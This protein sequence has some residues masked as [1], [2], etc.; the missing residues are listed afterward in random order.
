MQ[1]TKLQRDK[2][3]SLSLKLFG[4]ESRWRKVWEETKIFDKNVVIPNTSKEY[5][6]AKAEALAGG[7]DFRAPQYP[8]YRKPTF[9]ETI[10][11]LQ[12]FSDTRD[13]Q[14]L[15]NDELV[16][17]AAS[18]FTANKLPVALSLIVEEDKKEEFTNL[19]GLVP[20][21]RH[22]WIDKMVNA[23]LPPGTGVAIDGVAFVK[24]LIYV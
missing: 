16:Q 21:D 20:S 6:I 13:Y 23:D 2:L 18:D 11:S 17:K 24:A 14:T 8:I 7:Y 22:Q 15:K 3:D 1:P 4:I 12:Q 5:K 19:K 10:N 9:Q